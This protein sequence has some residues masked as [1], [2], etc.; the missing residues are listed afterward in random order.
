MKRSHDFGKQASK[1]GSHVDIHPSKQDEENK[2]SFTQA[3]KQN[4]QIK[5]S[6]T[7]ASKRD[8][9]IKQSPSQTNK[10]DRQDLHRSVKQASKENR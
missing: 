2:S 5:S 6:F 3:N 10:Q 4:S 9:Q 1:R 8:K 7:Q